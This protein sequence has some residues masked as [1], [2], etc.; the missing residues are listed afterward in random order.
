MDAPDHHKGST[1]T[2]KVYFVSRSGDLESAR[3]NSKSNL[4]VN[5]VPP[6][7]IVA[8]VDGK[9]E[10]TATANISK[11]VEKATPFLKKHAA[12]REGGKTNLEGTRN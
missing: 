7:H 1:V 4:L 12:S 11:C 8:L 10:A 2:C 9:D 6:T 5:E 3:K